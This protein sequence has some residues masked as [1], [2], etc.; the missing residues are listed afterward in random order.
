MIVIVT[1]LSVVGL[2]V[3]PEV[4]ASSTQAMCFSRAIFHR[5]PVTGCGYALHMAMV[6]S[7]A[8]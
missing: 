5:Q 3:P 1:L 4:L 7:V 8:L 2:L 6:F